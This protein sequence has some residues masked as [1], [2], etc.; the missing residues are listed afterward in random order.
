MRSRIDRVTLLA[1]AATLALCLASCESGRG[2]HAG[3]A[4]APSAEEGSLGSTPMLVAD[5]DIYLGGQPSPKD[6]SDAARDGSLRSV[7]NYRRA[8]ES[9]G[10]D[11]P[12]LLAGLG[13]EYHHLPYNGAAELTDEVFDGTFRIIESAPRPLMIHCASGNRVGAVWM[14]WRQLRDG[15]TEEEALA[16]ARRAGLRSE[17]YV[18]V[19]RRYVERRRTGGADR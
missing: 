13:L 10:F 14:A 3:A 19:A 9:T 8:E 17:A 15:Y 16:E 12:A 5:G 18:E 2:P 1:A 7:L 11:E 4:P 6:F